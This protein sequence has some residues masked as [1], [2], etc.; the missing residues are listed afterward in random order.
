MR[1][2]S[3]ERDSTGEQYRQIIKI[4]I[5]KNLYHMGAL[6]FKRS[7]CCHELTSIEICTTLSI[8]HN[9]ACESSIFATI[10][11]VP[12]VPTH[13]RHYSLVAAILTSHSKMLSYINKYA[14]CI[15][16]VK[17]DQIPP[18]FKILSNRFFCKCFGIVSPP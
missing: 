13:H 4:S 14:S 12:A 8:L 17:S 16:F 9:I 18:S 2:R 11:Q 10:D 15:A 5:I 7:I 1:C 3:K 6:T